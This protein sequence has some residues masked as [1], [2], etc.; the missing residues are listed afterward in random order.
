MA[1]V[2]PSACLVRCD[3]IVDLISRAQRP[4]LFRVSVTG[5]PPHAHKRVYD[6]AANT[7]DAAAMKGLDLFQKEM[8]H[9][10]RILDAL[11]LDSR[12]Q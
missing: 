4:F 2:K 9:P 12:L 10:L 5:K 1:I 6:I 11:G 8:S 3:A 7:D